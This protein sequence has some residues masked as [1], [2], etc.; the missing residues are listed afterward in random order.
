MPRVLRLSGSGWL[1]RVRW[2][3][4]DCR[5][6]PHRRAGQCGE[7]ERNC[8]DASEAPDQQNDL[9][10]PSPPSNTPRACREAE[11]EAQLCRASEYVGCTVVDGAGMSCDSRTLDRRKQ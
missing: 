2:L 1:M 8:T 5:W 7:A 11:L 6:R 10:R 9:R 3:L 4:P